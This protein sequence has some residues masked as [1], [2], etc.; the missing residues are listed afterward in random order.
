MS[1]APAPLKVPK[2]LP[3]NLTNYSLEVA[4]SEHTRVNYDIGACISLILQW[5]CVDGR[6]RRFLYKFQTRR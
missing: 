6:G 5:A 3:E 2:V 1:V 4:S